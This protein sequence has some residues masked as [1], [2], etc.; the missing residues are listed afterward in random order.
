MKSIVVSGLVAFF[1]LVITAARP[2]SDCVIPDIQ[3]QQ[4]LNANRHPQVLDS[5][6]RVD[7]KQFGNVTLAQVIAGERLLQIGCIVTEPVMGA[8]L[9]DL[10]IVGTLGNNI[11]IYDDNNKFHS[12]FSSLGG[13]GTFSHGDGSQVGDRFVLNLPVTA[14][15][16][17]LIETETTTSAT[18][19]ALQCITWIASPN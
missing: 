19:G 6:S 4:L 7:L 17:F 16:A 14:S 2:V 10:R 11:R 9:T 15:R 12:G 8:P 3:M 5:S 13:I 1:L 18:S